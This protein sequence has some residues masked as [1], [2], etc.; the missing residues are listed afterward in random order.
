MNSVM[1]EYIDDFVMV[2]LDDILVFSTTEH[3]HEHHLR[4]VFQGLWEHKLQAKLKKREFGKSCV[5]YLSY[6]VGSGEVYID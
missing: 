2:Y 3:E 6:I 1:R 5:K 4:L